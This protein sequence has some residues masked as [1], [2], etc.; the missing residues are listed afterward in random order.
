MGLLRKTFHAVDVGDGSDERWAAQMRALWPR[1]ADALT[2]GGRTEAGAARARQQ[3][4]EHM[5]ELVPGLDLLA[6]GNG[7]LLR[8]YDFNPDEVE[9]VFSR[10]NL[11]SHRDARLTAPRESPYRAIW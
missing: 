9:G 4:E 6:G 3:F 8:N 2:E 7:T 10:S 1:A 11:L 5:P